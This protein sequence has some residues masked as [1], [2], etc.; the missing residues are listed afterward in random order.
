ME[1]FSRILGKKTNVPLKEIFELIT[2]AT[3][4]VEKALHFY[5]IEQMHICCRILNSVA[6][7][8]RALLQENWKQ[9]YAEKY[10]LEKFL[11]DSM[12]NLYA[13]ENII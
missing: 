1:Y 2:D 5:N 13:S 6:R 9:V 12:F 10:A 7:L 11:E 4:H 3:N 8:E